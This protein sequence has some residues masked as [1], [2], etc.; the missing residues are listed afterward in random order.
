MITLNPYPKEWWEMLPFPSSNPV[1]EFLFLVFVLLAI[2]LFVGAIV[3]FIL[4]RAD[5]SKEEP[6]NES[7]KRR[8]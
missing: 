5:K 8:F 1:M 7:F 2:V 4:E 6:V 3:L